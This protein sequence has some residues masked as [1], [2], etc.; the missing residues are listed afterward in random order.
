M[1]NKEQLE[2]NHWQNI[3]R[4]GWRGY[5]VD[6]WQHKHTIFKQ[7]TLMYINR[8]ISYFKDK[9]I[10]EI[11]CGPAGFLT[12]I[13]SAKSIIGIDP[14]VDEYKKIFN[15]DNDKVKYINTE[16]E[17]YN[18][19]KGIADI[20]ICWNV[21]DHVENVHKT[22]QNIYD[23]MTDDGEFWL[24]VNMEDMSNNEEMEEP[25]INSPHPYKF[26]E[27]KLNKLLQEFN[28]K[29]LEK[30]KIINSSGL[31]FVIGVLKK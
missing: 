1:K 18:Y 29:W 24:A 16:I 2:L 30:A 4:N 5:L 21:L 14:L 20:V 25:N 7:C 17:N 23:M 28:F 11:G 12:D 8:D 27:K 13:T 26:N 31:T 3:V 19:D 15:M 6:E 10:M 9:R 22:L